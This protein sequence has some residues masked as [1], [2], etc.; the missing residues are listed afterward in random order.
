[1]LC[2]VTRRQL[3][4]NQVIDG[5]ELF[6]EMIDEWISPIEDGWSTLEIVLNESDD[7]LEILILT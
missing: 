4:M 3:A 2:T 5:Y 7:K 1:M 6:R